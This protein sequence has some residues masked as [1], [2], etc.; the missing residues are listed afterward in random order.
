MRTRI[1]LTSFVLPLC[2]LG[3]L[4]GV[5]PIRSGASSQGQDE[6]TAA[7]FAAALEAQKQADTKLTRGES[8][9]RRFQELGAKLQRTRAVRVIVQLRVAFRP[10]GAMRQAAE[11]LAQ[12]ASIRQAQDELLN[13][14]RIRNPRSLKRF[15]TLPFLAFSV[16]EAGLAALRSLSRVIDI[17]EEFFISVAQAQSPSVS[18]IGAPNAWASGYTGAGKTIAILGTGVDKNHQSLSGKVVSEAC[19]STDDPEFAASSLCPGGATESTE[20]DSGLN[21]TVTG[22]CAHGTSIAGV[23]AGVAIDANL[24]SIQVNSLVNDAD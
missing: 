18:L 20:P 10:E 16:D 12:R 6:V 1:V 9:E 24:I 8:A 13:G 2:L 3:L 4:F 19:Y 22:D 23:A 11:R 15:E 21:C 17:H 14:V 5:S 7:Q